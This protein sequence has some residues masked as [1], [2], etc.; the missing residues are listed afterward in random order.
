MSWEESGKRKMPC[1]CGKGEVE[2]T[3]LS[4]DWGQSETRRVMLCEECRERYDYDPRLIN[5]HPGRE[6]ER[7][8]VL[9]STLEAE[10]HEAALRES[11]LRSRYY[12]VWKGRFKDLRSKKDVWKILTVNGAFYPS[13]QTFYKHTKGFSEA[14]LQNYVDSFF[15]YSDKNRIV[16]ICE[17]GY[18]QAE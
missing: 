12:A 1:P 18:G 7:G 2:E 4:N 11:D 3:N 8:W 17:E 14:E 13:L 15:R 6:V 5:D 16:S 10:R 9:K